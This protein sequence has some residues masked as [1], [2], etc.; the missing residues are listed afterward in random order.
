MLL[1]GHRYNKHNVERAICKE[2]SQVTG[3]EFQLVR[4][5]AFRLLKGKVVSLTKLDTIAALVVIAQNARALGS[6]AD[7]L[8]G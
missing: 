6:A 5:S 3:S 8:A 1:R 2:T 4:I 7:D